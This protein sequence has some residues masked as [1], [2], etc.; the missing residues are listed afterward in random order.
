KNEKDNYTASHELLK[1]ARKSVS[2]SIKKIIA[3]VDDRETARNKVLA[4]KDDYEVIHSLVTRFTEIYDSLKKEENKFD[5]C[6]VERFALTLL[7]DEEVGKAVRSKYKYVFIDEYQDV[8]GIQEEIFNIIA[9]N[10]EFMVGDVK[11]SIYGF[12]GCNVKL[13]EDKY[14]EYF[15]KGQGVQLNHNF[16][17]VD[18]I[19]EFVN[20]IFDGV[21]TKKKFGVEYKTEARLKAGGVYPEGLGRAAFH[22]VYIPKPEKRT[23]DEVYDIY[24]DA[25]REVKTEGDYL[26][27]VVL[28]I[29]NEELGKTYYH[30][31]EE[32]YKQIELK[33]ICI[34]SRSNR[35]QIVPI[36]KTLTA[37][38]IK[39]VSEIETNVLDVKEVKTL[40]AFLRILD[41][42]SQDIPLAITLGSKIGGLS[43]EELAEIRSYGEERDPFYVRY[44]KAM[45]GTGVLAEK[46]RAFDSYIGELRTLADFKGARYV[47]ERVRKDKGLSACTL[48]GKLGYLKEKKVL[49]FISESVSGDK[50]LSVSEF[51]YK[52]DNSTDSFA[53]A[54]TAGADAVKVMSIHKSKGLEFPVVIVIGLEKDFKHYDAQGVA[55][56]D[57]DLGVAYHT[58]DDEKRTYSD[59]IMRKY[60]EH[61]I[62]E[63][64]KRDEARLFYV[65][66][67]R[68]MFSL[69]VIATIRGE[70]KVKKILPEDGE[71]FLDFMPSTIKAEPVFYT[72]LDTEKEKGRESVIVADHDEKVKE[73]IR[74]N[75]DFD[76][77]Y[78]EEI[79][80]PLKTS[81]TA[82][83]VEDEEPVAILYG[84]NGEEN[85]ENFS[86]THFGKRTP[87]EGNVAHK[88]I[89]HL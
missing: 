66:T 27:N 15:K 84:E 46:L 17:C 68:A 31:K 16:R 57:R 20:E 39:V 75:L 70:E 24:K 55:V 1:T 13:F 40:V 37:N 10:N 12:R 41:C 43:F 71:S 8:N 61:C 52:I 69:H 63:R 38:G 72:E 48:A 47:L 14:A 83:L 29:I 33:D 67:T 2:D 6:D 23:S 78:K 53:E 11:Q 30:F 56:F 32:R 4:T 42:F 18:K 79:R 65:A 82:N 28:K 25:T 22:K 3:D 7:R 51:L 45:A 87:K 64:D 36:I 26:S 80:L 54:E 5:F 85:A 60:F 34:L 77:L 35:G 89:K 86:R 44:T 9:N 19:I 88:V 62:K 76:Y 81:V 50:E 21:I 74:K 49:R 59:S 58:F 73:K